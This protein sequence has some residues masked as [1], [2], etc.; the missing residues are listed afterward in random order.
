MNELINE[1]ISLVLEDLNLM[2]N[3]YERSMVRVNLIKALTD[4]APVS[5]EEVTGKDAIKT[6]YAKTSVQEEVPELEDMLQKEMEEPIVEE[7]EKL[8]PKEIDLD[9]SV[10][11]NEPIIATMEDEEGNPFEIDVTETYYKLSDKL[12]DE[13][14]LELAKNITAYNLA[15]IYDELTQLPDCNDKMM[16]AYYLQQLGLDEVNGFISQ[17]TDGQFNL[18]HEFVNKDN[19]EYLV[20]EIANAMEEE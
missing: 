13:D 20:N 7:V 2:T 1:Q 16:L 9:K 17:L 18:L 15:P 4:L 11:T 8:E 19:L 12:S 5:E 6:D 14:K 10:V 3:P